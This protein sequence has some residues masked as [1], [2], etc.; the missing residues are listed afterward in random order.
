M[1]VATKFSRWAIAFFTAGSLVSCNAWTAL[2]QQRNSPLSIAPK[3]EV[4]VAAIASLLNQAPGSNIHI[5]GTVSQ[6]APFL[7][8]GAYEVQDPTGKIWVITQDPLPRAG[9][10]VLILGELKF[11]DLR[12]GA[13]DFGEVFVTEIAALDPATTRPVPV[14]NTIEKPKL[15]LDPYLLPHK[16]DSKTKDQG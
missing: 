16:E 12:L 2:S 5:N 1:T 10:E 6:S 8:G 15:N 4:P 11:H 9:T 13:N 3:Q 14:T 7:D